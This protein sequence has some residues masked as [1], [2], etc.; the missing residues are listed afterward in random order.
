VQLFPERDGRGR[1]FLVRA[2]VLSLAVHL[3]A[4]L[5]WPFVARTLLR[6]VP[7]ERVVAQIEPIT[8]ERR[9]SPTPTPSPT[10]PPK[11]AA[12]GRPLPAPRKPVRAAAPPLAA[13]P[14][15][16]LPTYAPNP[17][18]SAPPRRA[19]V[20]VPPARVVAQVTAPH[21]ASGAASGGALDTQQIAALD[22]TF[23]KTIDQAQRAA[24]AA[25]Q[26]DRPA[27]VQTMKRYAKVLDGP[28]SDVLS[29]DGPCQ[30]LD[31]GAVR[32][33]YTYYYIRC[34]VTFQ[35]GYR[36]TVSFPWP[37][38]FTRR[39][40]PFAPNGPRHF[41]GQPPPP[42]FVMPHPFALSRSVCYYYHDECVA[43]VKREEA[44]GGNP[45]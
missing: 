3:V 2:L 20:H 30:P 13:I 18:P 9:P 1:R 28:V 21:G 25:P 7:P 8:I 36:E 11:Q 19:K 33:P 39:E 42:G 45:Q 37:F 35:D 15:I 16:A 41:P 27:A 22:A 26:A 6:E 34:D 31:D 4:S 24:A 17:E 40:D 5:L 44:A 10:P 32:G 38:K 43:I 12:Q 23:R 14:K 29:S